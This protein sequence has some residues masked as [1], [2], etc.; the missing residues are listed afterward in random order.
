MT[1]EEYKEAATVYAPKEFIVRVAFPML[2]MEMAT[3]LFLLGDIESEFAQETKRRLKQLN[4][5]GYTD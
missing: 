1:R 4:E 5:L 3:T 2:L